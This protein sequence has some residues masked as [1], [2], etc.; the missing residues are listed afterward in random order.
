MRI[1]FI[2]FLF[3]LTVF[4]GSACW[5]K[6]AESGLVVITLEFDVDEN[7]KAHDIRILDA[8]HPKYGDLGISV[9]R[10]QTFEPKDRKRRMTAP[11]GFVIQTNGSTTDL[12][13]WKSEYYFP[14][15]KLSGFHQAW[16][17]KHLAA[18]KEPKL[19]SVATD[20]DAFVLRVLDLPTWGRPVAVRIEKKGDSIT[21]KIIVL[22]GNGG[23]APG[24]IKAEKVDEMSAAEFAKL[25]GDF[26][27]AGFWK[28]PVTDDVNG[29]DGNELLI[30]TVRN[31][32]YGVF[33]RWTPEHSS[34]ERGLRKLNKVVSDLLSQSAALEKEQHAA[35]Q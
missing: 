10:K 2:A 35:A 20:K 6:P 24:H 23:Y 13:I 14:S 21:R 18:M 5:G 22:S 27:R 34:T 7:G 1:G 26:E 31:G 29:L 15:D 16:F 12:Y 30:E 8:S 11:V 32:E 19:A 25:L 17:S 28:L 4:A 33:V 3:V 9:I